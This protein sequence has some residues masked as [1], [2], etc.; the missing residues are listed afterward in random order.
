MQENT[1]KPQP[2][3]QSD[4]LASEATIAVFGGGAG[5]GKSH[6]LLL[7]PL[8]HYEN[9][10]FGGVIFR[11]NSTQIRNTGGLWDESMKLYMP[12]GGHPRES[13]LEWTFPSG[14]NLKFAHLDLDTDI[15]KWQGSQIPFLAFDELTHFTENQFNYM[16]SRCRSTSGVP[17]YVR[18]TCNPD[19]ASWVRKFIAWWIG[20]DGLPIKERSGV[21]RWMIRI[22][23]QIIWADTPE[24]LKQ[25]YGDHQLPMSVT[26]IPSRLFDNK[27]LMNNDPSYLAKLNALSRIER[28]RLLDGNWDV[29]ATAGTFFR[30]EWFQIVDAIPAGWTRRCRFWDRASTRPHENNKDP[31]WTRGLLLYEYP[32]GRFLVGDLRS[33]RDSPAKVEDLIKNTASFDGTTNTR[34]MCQQDPGSAGVKE[35][36]HFVSML[37]GYDVGTI[38]FSKDKITRAKAVSAQCEVGNLMVLR[39]PWN[40]EF[41][42]ETEGFPDLR[43]D[44]IVDT[45]SGAFNELIFGGR[46]IADVL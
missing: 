25:K 9:P 4:F 40:D 1:I 19:V 31:D 22:D 13:Y 34:I 39:A 36:D 33:L 18:G 46:S 20:P 23:E 3:P 41:F 37:R 32:D 15:Y 5:G 28:A 10:D 45:L 30:R 7:E 44:D 24:E 35:A 38:T 26:F 16:L 11:K 27:I 8:R 12:L 17:G 21:L 29:K 2:G 43:H 42:S 14:A 6:A